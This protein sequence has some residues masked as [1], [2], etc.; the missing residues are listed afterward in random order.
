M[1]ISGAKI[2]YLC[3]LL[4][5]EDLRQLDTLFAELGSTTSENLKSIILGLGAYF[6]LLIC[7]QNKSA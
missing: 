1:P 2:Q 7:W 3:K 5:G 4:C 6:F